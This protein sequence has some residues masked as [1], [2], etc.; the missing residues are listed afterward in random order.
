MENSWRKI[1]REE[2]SRKTN[3]EVHQE[4]EEVEGEA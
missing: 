2:K 3:K 1:N 4:K